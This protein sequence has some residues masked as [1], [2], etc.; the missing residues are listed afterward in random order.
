MF[1]F[2]DNKKGVVLIMVLGTLMVVTLL[3]SVVLRLISSHYRLSHHEISRIQAYYAAMAGVNYAIDKL[4]M[5]NDP[6]CWSDSGDYTR[7]LCRT[8]CSGCDIN[9]PDLPPHIQQVE[10]N[11]GSPDPGKGN[12]L[13]ITATTT[14]LYAP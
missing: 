14:Y 7:R 2:I 10:I 3:A 13:P 6:V 4:R 1:K 9:D 11:I 12:S 5:G 8:G